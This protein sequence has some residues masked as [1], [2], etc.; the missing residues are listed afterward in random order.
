MSMVCIPS[1][2]LVRKRMNF[3]FSSSE[4]EITSGLRIGVCIHFPLIAG[5]LFGLNL[6]GTVHAV[7]VSL[8]SV[9]LCLEGLG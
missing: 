2:T 5:T 3:S 9:H 8:S 6:A 7:T 1:E 4:L